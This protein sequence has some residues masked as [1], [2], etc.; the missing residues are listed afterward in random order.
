MASQASNIGKRLPRCHVS[1]EVLSCAAKVAC[2]FF[3]THTFFFAAHSDF[4]EP[5]PFAFQVVAV[6]C[7]HTAHST[8]HHFNHHALHH[9]PWR[10]AGE[11]L[12]WF[13]LE[14]VL[15]KRKC[16]CSAATGH[17]CCTRQQKIRPNFLLF[18]SEGFLQ[19]GGPLGV[20]SGSKAKAGDPTKQRLGCLYQ[21]FDIC[22]TWCEPWSPRI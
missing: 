10:W 17:F 20:A 13:S 21:G 12:F 11:G 4:V 6:Q 8:P 5:C 14:C 16:A 7:V 18:L 3:N 2:Q 1:S 9:E 15:A 22:A 19:A